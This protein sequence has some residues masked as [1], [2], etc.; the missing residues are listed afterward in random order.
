MIYAR[1]PYIVHV[2]DA[3]LEDIEFKLYVYNGTKDTDKGTADYEFAID[4]INGEV[5]F[6][7]S[8]FIREALINRGPGP[9]GQGRYVWV[10]TE[11]D[12]D[13]GAGLSGSFSTYEA[14]QL[15]CYGY[16]T[17]DEGVNY[18][19]LATERPLLMNVNAFPTGEFNL[20]K[21]EASTLHVPIQT[22]GPYLGV[23][24]YTIDWYP[25]Y[26][27]GGTLI[28]TVNVTA[29]ATPNVESDE[30]VQYVTVPATAKSFFWE[31]ASSTFTATKNIYNLPDCKNTPTRV[32]FINKYG[33]KEEIQF[34]GRAIESFSVDQDQYK[35]TILSAGTYE[36]WQRQQTPLNKRANKR[37]S[38]STGMYP[39]GYNSAFKQLVFSESVWILI[40]GGDPTAFNDYRPVNIV[41]TDFEYKYSRYDKKI[42]YTFTFEYANS[43]INDIS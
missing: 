39:E 8:P 28:S 30:Q 17:P 12:K 11:I 6:D 36:P 32:F 20:V 15:A 14:T 24:D 2:D 40:D 29:S 13:T 4:A 33:V 3:N 25:E 23:N 21:G 41:E 5:T 42:E 37:L 18:T 7:I 34:F 19:T 35:R 27:A 26:N 31:D 38:V 22:F 1:S 16:T 10:T 9:Q 43:E